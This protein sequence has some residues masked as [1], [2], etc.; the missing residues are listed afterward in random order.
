MLTAPEQIVQD[1]HAREDCFL[2]EPKWR[3]VLSSSYGPRLSGHKP[4]AIELRN[5]LCDVLVDFPGMVQEEAELLATSTTHWKVS[6]DLPRL[7]RATQRALRLQNCMNSWYGDFAQA[8]PYSAQ[9]DPA[10]IDGTLESDMDWSGD[11]DRPNP[12]YDILDCVATTVLARLDQML[13]HLSSLQP[14][15]SPDGCLD[16]FF[17]TGVEARRQKA[18]ATFEVVRSKS[19]VSA[20][21][22]KFGL[23]QIGLEEWHV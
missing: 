3:N 22:L 15:V 9:Q 10:S 17:L 6:H 4:G 5:S 12:L 1:M 14:G 11:H 23:L 20:K 16:D 13:L 21:P 19:S 7:E 2:A 8:V 18:R